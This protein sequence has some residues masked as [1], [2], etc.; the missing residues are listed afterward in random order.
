MTV[1][2]DEPRNESSRKS[3]QW[4]EGKWTLPE[5]RKIKQPGRV[6]QFSEIVLNQ[7]ADIFF[8]C[9]LL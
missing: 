1:R 8:P 9:Y 6:L 4:S 3:S 7:F 5:L 2:N